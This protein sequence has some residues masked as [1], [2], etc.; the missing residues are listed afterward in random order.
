M[1]LGGLVGA[2]S[3]AR[4]APPFGRFPSA[5]ATRYVAV[6]DHST[7][8]WL[9]QELGR[10]RLDLVRNR[11]PRA[12]NGGRMGREWGGIC[13][14]LQEGFRSC[15]GRVGDKRLGSCSQVRVGQQFGQL[16]HQIFQ[17]EGLHG[18]GARQAQ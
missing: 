13:G 14:V 1:L 4:V 10:R 16:H 12:D 15:V 9:L 2:R 18:W 7:G 11:H 3:L 17:W 6:G 5:V 8:H